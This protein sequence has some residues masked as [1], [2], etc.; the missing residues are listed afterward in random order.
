M[1]KRNIIDGVIVL[2]CAV[3]FF[4]LVAWGCWSRNIYLEH[5]NLIIC[6]SDLIQTCKAYKNV[7]VLDSTVNHIVIKDHEN[8][9]TL[10]GR[11]FELK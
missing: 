9:F 10:N 8:T 6:E 11:I 5:K 7:E 3:C 2:V 4:L 1:N